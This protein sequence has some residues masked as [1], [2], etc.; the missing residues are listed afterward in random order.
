MRTELALAALAIGFGGV[1]HA[2]DAAHD[3]LEPFNRAMFHFNEKVDEYALKPVALGYRAITPRLFRTGVSNVLANLNAPVIFANDVFQAAPYRAGTTLA[4]FGINTTVGVAGIF[5]VAQE[6]GLEK[7]GEDF[8]QT[9]GRWRVGA[10]PYLVLPLLGPTNIRDGFG[11]IVDV[12]ISP[13]TYAQFDGDDAFRVTRAV[14]GVVSAREAGI[15]GLDNIYETS[16]DPYVTIR[17]SYS[18]LRESAIHNGQ[19]NVKDL[20]EFDAIPSATETPPPAEPP[21]EAPK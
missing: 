10:G 14:L 18:L 13:L 4:R 15:E 11:R 8:G 21:V 7:H 9:L 12:G 6:V 19:T 1:A 2:Q 3:P 20:P 16:I 5:D 17:T